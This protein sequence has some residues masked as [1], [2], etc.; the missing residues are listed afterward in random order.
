MSDWQVGDLAV[1]LKTDKW[2]GRQTGRVTDGP[3]YGSVHKVA[4]V[5]PSRCGVLCLELEGIETPRNRDGS[6]IPWTADR[7]RKIRPDEQEPCEVEFVTLLKRSK[8]RQSA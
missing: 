1:C 4:W 3:S 5:G 7:F 8:Q 2:R 6:V